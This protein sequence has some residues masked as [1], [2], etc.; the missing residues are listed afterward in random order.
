MQVVPD[1][2]TLAANEIRPVSF[3]VDSTLAF[4]HWS[5]TIVLQTETGQNPFFMGGDEALPIGVRVVCRPPDWDMDAGIYPVTMNMVIK[6]DI[7]GV[8]S[9]DAEDIVAAYIGG[10]LRGRAHVTYV[11]QVN[12]YLAYLTIYGE[13][14]ESGEPVLLQVWD[15]SA[16]LRYGTVQEAFTFQPDN[17]IGTPIAPQVVH[18][19]SLVLREIPL[20]NGWNWVSFNLSF[21]DPALNPAL[22][23]LNHPANDLIKGQSAFSMYSSGWFGS[24]TSLGNTTMYQFRADEPDTLNMLGNLIDPTS[25]NIPLVSGWNWLGYLPNFAL[26]VNDALSSLPA[27]IGDIIKSQSAFAQYISGFGWLGNLTFMQPPQG[28]QLR[29][30]NAGVVTYPGSNFKPNETVDERGGPTPAAYWQ[31]NPAQY[32][33]SMTL[34]GMRSQ[35]GENVTP[36]NTE[37]GAFAGNELRGAAQAVW[38]EPV[39]AHLYFLTTYANTPGELL[40]FKQYDPADGSITDLSQTMY[41]ASDLHQGAI[42]DPVPFTIQTTGSEEITPSQR[43]EIQPNPFH[44]STTMFLDSDRELETTVLITDVSGRVQEQFRWSVRPGKNV[45]TW[46]PEKPLPAGVYFVK[47]ATSEG[48]MARKVVR[49]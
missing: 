15:A 13:S 12:Q 47:I 16:C 11:P 24:L 45:Y 36:A 30:A 21:P 7:E 38:V 17:V 34:I 5:D 35:N 22:S 37:L 44:E 27:Q 43:F 6:P 48:A 49:E 3:K 29:L 19:N 31:I 41:F 23:S 8:F 25:V 1:Q 42:E 26:P 10:E 33:H 46:L 20:S 9:A 14:D 40:H 39:G 2:G 28:Y 32:E 18:T 4:G